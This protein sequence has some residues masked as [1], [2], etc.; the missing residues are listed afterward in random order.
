MKVYP[1]AGRNEVT[2]FAG[3]V[4]QVK[5]KAAPEKG[6]ANRELVDFLSGLLGI[7]RSSL[8][9]V[10]GETSRHKLLAIEGLTPSEAIKRLLPYH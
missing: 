5:I 8:T 4:L 3:D 2:G 6:K 1:G 7:K 10:K 9:V